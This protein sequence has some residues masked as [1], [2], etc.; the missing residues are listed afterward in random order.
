M[1]ICCNGIHS[2]LSSRC[3][4]S[5]ALLRAGRVSAVRTTGCCGCCT[6]RATVS[7][8]CWLRLVLAACVLLCI[9]LRWW[10]LVARPAVVRSSAFPVQRQDALRLFLCEP[11]TLLY[12]N[13]IKVFKDTDSV[14]ETEYIRGLQRVACFAG[15]CAGAL[16]LHR[17][18]SA[19]A[20]TDVGRHFSAESVDVR[21]DWLPPGSKILI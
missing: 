15:G 4:W 3:S 8:V 11:T 18:E 20:M 16:A 2:V 6:L 12:S 1:N 9:V 17:E 13:N 7:S 5:A 21:R 19:G 14:I 10:L